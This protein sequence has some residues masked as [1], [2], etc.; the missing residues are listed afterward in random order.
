MMARI[1]DTTSMNICAHS[2]TTRR[3]KLSANAPAH[4]DSSMIGSVVEDCTRATLCGASTSDA[5]L[6]AAPTDWMRPPKFEAMLA[7]KT[8]RKVDLCS[9][10]G[11]KFPAHSGEESGTTHDLPQVTNEHTV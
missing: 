1:T 7:I 3:S 11:A 6:Q 10:A 9:G 2:I 8:A 4:N 5:I